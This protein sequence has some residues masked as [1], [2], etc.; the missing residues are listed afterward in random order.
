MSDRNE[1]Y[2]KLLENHLKLV[3]EKL[4]NLE[5]KKES[6]F[7]Y[8]AFTQTIIFDYLNNLHTS[9]IFYTSNDKDT[10]KKN[11]KGYIKNKLISQSIHVDMKKEIF[12]YI[13]EAI[14]EYVREH[15]K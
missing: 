6:Y 12:Q 4:A 7:N 1:A 10:V 9:D 3:E 8:A 13:N 14:E 11:V 15:N 2:I 5:Q